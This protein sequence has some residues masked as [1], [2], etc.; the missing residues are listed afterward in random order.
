MGYT[1]S[2]T[3]ATF[4]LL[5]GEIEGALPTP[6]RRTIL[7]TTLFDFE[8]LDLVNNTTLY[9]IQGCKCGTKNT[10]IESGALATKNTSWRC[11]DVIPLQV[12]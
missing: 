8:V 12:S 3:V 1:G 11:K 7:Q 9:I 4:V 6:T 10:A 5:G 2:F